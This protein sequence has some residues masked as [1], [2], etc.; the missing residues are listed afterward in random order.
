MKRNILLLFTCILAHAAIAQKDKSYAFW[1]EFNTKDTGTQVL[2]KPEAL[3][4]EKCIDR[5]YKY[6]IPFDYYD[7]PVSSSN[8][9]KLT[10]KG[11]KILAQSRW[12]NAVTIKATYKEVA[13]SLK[14]WKFIKQVVY[15]G[16]LDL[17]DSVTKQR[18]LSEMISM[19]EA[20][21]DDIKKKKK[22]TLWYGKASAQNLML[23]IQVLHNRGFDGT[24]I[25]IAVIDA[26]FKNARFLPHFK[27]LFDSARILGTWDFVAAEEN[28]FDDDDHGLS[29]FSC[30]GAKKPFEYVGTATQANFWLL[31]TEQAATEQLLEEALWVQA[32]EFA[33]SVGVDIINS[34]L[35][36]NLFD[37][38]SMNHKQ[39][40][41]NGQTAII[42]RGASIASSRGLL[43]VNSAGN[44]GDNKWRQI[45]FPAD[46][47]GILTVGSVDQKLNHSL[48]SSI[49]PSADKRIKPDVVAMGENTYVVSGSGT[50]H[51]GNGTSYSSPIMAGVTACLLQSNIEATPEQMIK[52]LQLSSH[53]YYIPDKFEGYGLPDAALADTILKSM[54]NMYTGDKCLD[55]RWLKDKNAHLVV[56]VKQPQKIKILVSDE[57][58]T[59][60]YELFEKIKSPGVNR[61]PVK[62]TAKLPDGV[63]EIK[64]MFNGGVNSFKIIKSK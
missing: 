31:R 37:D 18:D 43:I 19:L 17:K 42:S 57:L 12:L 25:D 23:N 33:D 7:I 38:K 34:S 11:Y 22:D 52:A 49:G 1:I 8:K 55:A 35:G 64:V 28:V 60:S 45:G 20:K 30:I 14:G 58:G 51:Q 50:V 63:Y 36:Y 10:G 13:D 6:K 32:V 47:N 2:S 39:K 59:F 46:A 62:K 3:F 15:L 26:G 4:T 61:F 9:E 16:E 53:Q 44:E 56:Y 27:H 54:V 24:G 41:L 29:V 48:F 40:E 5:R 21:F